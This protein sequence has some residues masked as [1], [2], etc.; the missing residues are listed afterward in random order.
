MPFT[1]VY[2]DNDHVL[3]H[4]LV[5]VFQYDIA[6]ARRGRLR[7]AARRRCRSG[8][9]RAWPSIYSLGRDDPTTAMWMRDAVMRNDLPTIKQ[10]TSDPR[11][12]PY[13]Y[14]Q[15]LWA[16]IG[17]RWGDR[18]CQRP[19]T[20][21][22]SPRVGRALK[23]VPRPRQQRTVDG[24]AGSNTR[25]VPAA[26]A[27]ARAARRRGADGA[28][29]GTRRA[30]TRTCR[31]RSAPTARRSRSLLDVTSS[32]STSS[33]RTRAPAKSSKSTDRS[34]V[35]RR[36]STRSASSPRRGLVA[37][38]AQARVRALRR[39]RQRDR[40]PRREVRRH[41]ATHQAAGLGAMADPAWCPDGQDDGVL[42]HGGR[43]RR[44]LRGRPRSRCGHAPNER[45][46]RRPAAD[47]VARRPHDRLRHRSR[48]AD[49]PRNAHVRIDAPG[50]HGRRHRGR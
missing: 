47:V 46:L 22:R 35:E 28:R 11:Y 20:G 16:Y 29:P 31:R 49:R 23:R 24:L 33:S 12:F 40:D 9:S 8:S 45:S 18:G 43:H 17:G 38:R 32:P 34:N 27:G 42:G 3:G 4:E 19:C 5:H 39:R 25:D 10:L 7:T 13:R 2:A 44:S 15:A 41:R 6:T 37:G 21:P 14:G 36:T 26:D 30:A 50:A 1:G 48:P